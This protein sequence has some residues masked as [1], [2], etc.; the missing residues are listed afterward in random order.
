MYAQVVGCAPSDG[1]G[2]CRSLVPRSTRRIHG[3]V[4]WSECGQTLAASPLA[5]LSSWFQVVL[6]DWGSQSGVASLISR[7]KFMNLR[8]AIISCQIDA[9]PQSWMWLDKPHASGRLFD[10]DRVVASQLQNTAWSAYALAC[11]VADSAQPT[12]PKFAG[13][14]R[15]SSR[16]RVLVI[17][18]SLQTA[19]TT[20]PDCIVHSTS[21]LPTELSGPPPTDWRSITAPPPC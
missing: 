17:S 9:E 6:V 8:I 5:R 19:P 15:C 16:S 12:R 20:R 7:H 14:T 4:F 13:P 3:C 2:L 18:R 11:A 21:F 10:L 1:G